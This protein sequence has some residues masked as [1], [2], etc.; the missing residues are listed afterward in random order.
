MNRLAPQPRSGPSVWEL[1]ASGLITESDIGVLITDNGELVLASTEIRARE[2]GTAVEAESEAAGQAS[3]GEITRHAPPVHTETHNCVV[4]FTR[5]RTHA[6]VECGHQCVCGVCSR[7]PRL[8]G[9]CP[10]CRKESKFI[11]I[12]K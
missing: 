10:L 12:F 1:A 2:R 8:Y 7:D 3:R 11:R 5:E 6:A 9:K 4:C